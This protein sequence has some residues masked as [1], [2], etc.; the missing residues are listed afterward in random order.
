MSQTK[1]LL[2]KRIERKITS[3]GD[4]E[5][6]EHDGEQLFADDTIDRL[7]DRFA[8]MENRDWEKLFTVKGD[9]GP[10]TKI[11]TKDIDAFIHDLEQDEQSWKDDHG[12]QLTAFGQRRY[13]E[14]VGEMGV[15][16]IAEQHPRKTVVGAN[17]TTG[18]AVGV[19]GAD[20]KRQDILIPVR[21]FEQWLFNTEVVEPLFDDY[22]ERYPY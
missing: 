4:D 22:H 21:S 17:Y 2:P 6:F 5:W 18:H 20:G 19:G 9:S 15:V 3:R 7:Y 12:D 8:E 10:R 16:E 13:G 14:P 11:R 1:P